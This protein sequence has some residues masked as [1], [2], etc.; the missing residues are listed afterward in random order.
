MAALS[1]QQKIS[2]AQMLAA[3]DATDGAGLNTAQYGAMATF[4][5]E[6]LPAA[7]VT[8]TD[9]VPYAYSNSK[10]DLTYTQVWAIFGRDPDEIAVITEKLMFLFYQPTVRSTLQDLGFV[11]Y[12]ITNVTPAQLVNGQDMSGGLYGVIEFDIR[13]QVSN[14]Y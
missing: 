8:F 4:S 6:Q 9:A 2:A 11:E 1:T 3:V 5:H 7:L 12:T 14:P 10:V 13:I